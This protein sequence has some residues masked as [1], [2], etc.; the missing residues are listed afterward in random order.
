MKSCSAWRFAAATDNPAM[1][2]FLSLLGEKYIHADAFEAR[3]VRGY[4]RQQIMT[5]WM[6]E[7]S[8]DYV[9]QAVVAVADGLFNPP[10]TS[11]FL[12][13]LEWCFDSPR[14][15]KEG[16]HHCISYVSGPA[17]VHEK[18]HAVLMSLGLRVGDTP[19]PPCCPLPDGLTEPIRMYTCG[20]QEAWKTF[21]EDDVTALIEVAGF[22]DVDNWIAVHWDGLPQRPSREDAIRGLLYLFNDGADLTE[23]PPGFRGRCGPRN[24]CWQHKSDQRDDQQHEDD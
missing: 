19:L 23:L 7:N 16:N 3:W 12:L 18:M 22:G 13:D 9:G 8:P 11:C 14:C 10:T 24:P 20:D 17:R 5:Y 21:D 1:T 4:I 2:L 6:L 15:T